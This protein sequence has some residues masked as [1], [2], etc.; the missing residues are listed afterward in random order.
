VEVVEYSIAQKS[1]VGGW[2]REKLRP[3][4]KVVRR[5]EVRGLHVLVLP[6]CLNLS[7]FGIRTLWLKLLY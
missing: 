6:F 1:G 5:Q 3:P 2:G 4:C 7:L